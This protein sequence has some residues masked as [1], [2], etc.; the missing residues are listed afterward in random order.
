MRSWVER[1]APYKW[2]AILAISFGVLT[3]AANL[4]LSS[5]AAYLIAKAAQHPATI[6]LLWVPIVGVRAFGTSRGVFRYGD[7]YFSHDVT[8]RLLKDLRVRLYQAL[9]PLALVRWRQ[10]LSGDLLTRFSADVET[11]QNAYLGLLSPTLIAVGGILIA[12][13]IGWVVAPGVGLGLLTLLTLVGFWVP[14]IMYRVTDESARELVARRAVL[15]SRWVDWIYGLADLLMLNQDKAALRWHDDYQKEWQALIR[16]IN[17]LK[18]WVA[19]LNDGLN[20]LIAWAILALAADL[21]LHHR[22]SGVEVSV[23]VFLALA[24]FEAIRPLPGA[25]QMSG[26]LLSA[27]RRIEEITRQ[28]V[29]V[30]QITWQPDNRP[31]AVDLIQ[32]S[33][34]HRDQDPWI[35]NE[36]DLTLAPAGVTVLIGESGAG[37]S[38]LVQLLTGQVAPSAG[39]ILVNGHPLENADPDAWLKRLAVVNQHPHIFDTTLRQNLLLARPDAS[40]ADLWQALAQ[41]ELAE[42]ARELPEGLDSPVGDHG[43]TLSGGQRKRLALA[44]VL[45]KRDT[46]LWILDEPTEG[47]DLPLAQQVMQR[48]LTAGEGKTVLW[49]SHDYS[50]AALVDRVVELAQGQFREIRT[51]RAPQS[52]SVHG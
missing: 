52:V 7:R 33:Y 50:Y 9:E 48:V 42:W 28:P 40:E 27:N 2:W 39:Q 41:V 21:A 47:L 45:L 8:F 5:T 24:S 16:R 30:R 35:F 37:K 32:L 46:T 4:G 13:G 19:G 14:W 26:Q 29:P 6:L 20:H 12:A 11:L 18:G 31:P 38:S 25:F 15:A 36:A 1:L 3:V 43:Q 10:Y 23:A 49:I 34:R 51:A 22:I 17:R 44:R